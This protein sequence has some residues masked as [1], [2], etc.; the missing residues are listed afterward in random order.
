MSNRG[1]FSAVLL[2]VGILALLSAACA[3]QSND[4]T[5]RATS[6]A[7]PAVTT[8]PTPVTLSSSDKQFVMEAAQ[9]GSAEVQLG[10]LAVQK[11]AS[12]DVKQF[13]QRM[14]DDHSRVGDELKQFASRKNVSL[15]SEIGA[16]HQEVIDRLSKLS[17]KEFD[18]A[19]MA[20]M[21]KDHEKDVAA[22]DRISQQGNDP[23]LRAWTTKSLPTL[24]EH[25]QMAQDIARKVGAAP[26]S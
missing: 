6:S 2:M 5:S 20:E 16:Q 15:S 7:S 4:E 9:G 22:F 17:G 13:G 26:K 8:S 12:S 10:N 24:R 19:Y 14:V 21:L 18:R 1:Q 25:L 3:T 23:D 11:A